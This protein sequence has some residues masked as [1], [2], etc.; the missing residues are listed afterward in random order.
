[1]GGCEEAA[2]EPGRVDQLLAQL[3][4]GDSLPESDIVCNILDKLERNLEIAARL[5][6]SQGGQLLVGNTRYQQ[7][8]ISCESLQTGRDGPGSGLAGALAVFTSLHSELA[9]R[10]AGDGEEG[11]E[12]REGYQADQETP[13]EPT[14][15]KKRK[16]KVCFLSVFYLCVIV[17]FIQ[18]GLG[19]G[20]TAAPAVKLAGDQ[21]GVNAARL[22][23]LTRDVIFYTVQESGPGLTKLLAG[24]ESV[25]ALAAIATQYS[26]GA[27]KN[28][29]SMN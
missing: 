9:A 4:A 26:Q 18:V 22:Q 16:K 12:E 28:I 14:K 25:P 6:S 2:G 1:M 24:A 10:E 5:C 3:E 20:K 7:T 29:R 11:K 27:D 23:F 15:V 21:D 8:V 17:F 13:A 19:R